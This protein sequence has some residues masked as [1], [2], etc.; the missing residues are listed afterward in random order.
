[1]QRTVTAQSQPNADAR[2]FANHGSHPACDELLLTPKEVA[3]RLRVSV[4]SLA[5][6][7]STKRHGL[8]FTKI[9]RL[10]RYRES[11]VRSFIERRLEV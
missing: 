10:V 1:M 5:V 11:D 8:P 3:R 2:S 7:R 9:G 4:Q 6:W